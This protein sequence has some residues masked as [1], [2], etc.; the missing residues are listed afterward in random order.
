[1]PTDAIVLA[2]GAG[3]RLGGAV[4]KAFVSLAGEPLVIRAVRAV[5]AG[6]ADRIVVVVAPDRLADAAAILEA[7]EGASLS[8]AAGGASR[9][10]STRL[11]L[12]GLRGDPEDVVIVHDAAR[13]L[14]GPATFRAVIGAVLAGADGATPTLPAL[15]TIAFV[16]G[17]RITDVPARSTVVRVQTPQAFRRA[18]LAR[19]HEAAAAAA[20]VSATDDCGLVLSY[21]PDARIVAVP[22]DERNLKITTPLDL[23]LATRLLAQLDRERVEGDRSSR[24]SSSG[25]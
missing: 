22:G 15:D 7:P 24:R 4:P 17:D 23:E 19:A 3:E 13:A 12:A 11:G 5:A 18:V 9:V 16:A 10:E 6:G 1:V 8:I 21:V 25:T 20:D 14:A 2:A